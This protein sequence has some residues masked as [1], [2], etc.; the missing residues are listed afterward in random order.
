MKSEIH[1][2]LQKRSA[3][4]MVWYNIHSKMVAFSIE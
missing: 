4:N 2:I 1:V 3:R